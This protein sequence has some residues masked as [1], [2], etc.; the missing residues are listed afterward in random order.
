MSKEERVELFVYDLIK[1]N[2]V[3]NF[4]ALCLRSLQSVHDVKHISIAVFGKEY[5]FTA[6]CGIATNFVSKVK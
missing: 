1:S 2:Q 5:T 4:G 3:K 6:D